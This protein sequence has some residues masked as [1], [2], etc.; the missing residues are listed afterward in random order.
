MNDGFT[1]NSQMCL[2]GCFMKWNTA[3]QQQAN[4]SN[5]QGQPNILSYQKSCLAAN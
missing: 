5:K 2:H 4:L 3:R 1:V